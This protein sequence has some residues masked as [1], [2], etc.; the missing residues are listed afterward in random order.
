MIFQDFSCIFHDF[1]RIFHALWIFHDFS[2][3][4]H[5]FYADFSCIFEIFGI[6]HDFHVFFTMKKEGKKERKEKKQKKTEKREKKEG[7]KE[8]K[9][10][11]EE[12]RRK[13][14]KKEE[15]QR[16]ER[17]KTRARSAYLTE[18]SSPQEKYLSV[19]TWW[20]ASTVR[21]RLRALCFRS[22]TQFTRHFEYEHA[23]TPH[24]K[25]WKKNAIYQALW[26]RACAYSP[27]KIVK[28]HFRRCE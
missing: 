15:K 3:I 16:K 9:R 5:D 27:W 26:V 25:S 1:R 23:P 8:K 2:C 22:K 19:A 13:R 14:K 7:K 21:L 17:K 6:L 11:K 18:N 28:I 12:E 4:F 10:K 24:E 20:G